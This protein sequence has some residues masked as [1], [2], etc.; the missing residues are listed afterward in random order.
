MRI[1][2][3]T[4]GGATTGQAP[5]SLQALDVGQP[6]LSLPVDRPR[7]V[8]QD[9]AAGQLAIR[10]DAAILARIGALAERAGTDAGT[11]LLSQWLV[12]LA[13]LSGQAEFSL[14]LATRAD[15]D[16]GGVLHVSLV[17]GTTVSDLVKGIHAARASA[18][19]GAF[20]TADGTPGVPS[21]VVF[22]GADPSTT[23]AGTHRFDLSLAGI[24]A[25]GATDLRLVYSEALFDRSSAE[26]FAGCYQTLLDAAANDPSCAFDRLP[27]ISPDERRQ[28]IHDWNQ[29]KVF[30][31]G[32]CLSQAF[33]SSAARW[34]DA[35]AVTYGDA[36][37]TYAELNIRANRMAHHL[38][39]LGVGPD[40]R[41]AL[42]VERGLDMVV[43][44]LAVLKAGGAY[45]PLDPVY[46]IDRLRFVLEDCGP[47]AI[48]AARSLYDQLQSELPWVDITDDFAAQPESN[49]VSPDLSPSSLA[50]VI[51]TSGSTGQPKGVMIEHQD[52]VRL[53]D[54]TQSWFNFSS[55]DVWT[56][57]HSY[58][59]D[60]SVWE[61]WGAFLHGGRLVVVPKETARSPRDFYQLVSDEKVTILNQTPSAFRS[62]IAAQG[63]S[64]Q[65]HDLRHV[66]FGGETL[67]LASLRPWY[68]NNVGHRCE[69]VNGYG[70][71]ETTVFVTFRPLAAAD[72]ARRG[73]SP[74]GTCIPDQRTYVLDPHGE[75]VPVG[76]VGELYVGGAGIARGYL[77]R[78]ELS[79]QRFLPDPFTGGRMYRSGDLA[80]WL[81]DG[82][83]EFL[84][85]NDFQVKIRGFRIELGEIEAR[86]A[87]HPDIGDVVVLARDDDFGEKRLVAYFVP[88]AGAAVG[89]GGINTDAL[90]RHVGSELPEHMVPS[91][92]VQLTE[93]PLTPNGKMDRTALPAP[94]HARPSLATAYEP[95]ANALEQLLCSAFSRVLGIDAIGRHDNFFS[96]GGNSM[97]AIR[98]L[99]AVR[100][101]RAQTSVIP[102]TTVFH[103][104]T[105]ATLALA[106]DEP[107]ATGIDAARL[108]N[109]LRR[110]GRKFDDEPIAI[111]AMAGRFPGAPMSRH[112]G[113]TCARAA[114]RSPVSR[115]RTSIPPSA[116]RRMPGLREGARRHRRRRAV[117]RRVLRHLA[118]RSR[119]DGSAAAHLPRAVL[120]V[121]G[122]RRPRA[123][124]LRGADRRLRRHVQRHL[125]PAPC[126]RASRPDRAARRV[127]GDAGQ[128]EGLH[129]HARRAQ[130]QPD[131]AGDQRAH[132]LLDLAGGD[133]AGGRQPARR[134]VRHGARRRRVDHLS[135]AQRLPATRKASMLSPDGHTRSFDARGAGHRVQRR[136]GGGAAQ[137]PV[138]CARRRRPDPRRDP[139]RR[140]STT[141]APR[142]PASPRRASTGR[143]R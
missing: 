50:Y 5:A 94:G 11:V 44:V 113:T 84:G 56:L 16:K 13:R 10:L 48:L 18:K 90:R 7:T 85:R 73:P 136:R 127:P 130:A 87:T 20:F 135:A 21:I 76:V 103:S 121:P 54:A 66:I 116:C 47:V 139:R 24:G 122:A 86:L 89:E 95:A 123:G 140:A 132:R 62:F 1:D 65:P 25:D 30:P 59:F 17:A 8:G 125:L 55:D 60:F 110:G 15:D 69:L 36:K 126:C 75:P 96:L 51:Y 61:I 134:P 49:P 117:R 41:V 52:V 124:R 82:S 29:G 112:S 137:A 53:F 40:K 105:P 80:R 109:A 111:I 58:A 72:V 14:G 26:R 77:N 104:P 9:A 115:P 2:S 57:F 79:A 37:L 108:G 22:D 102:A 27:M 118:A 43:G 91:A 45:V 129:R 106:L 46:P 131:R 119:A 74:I 63:N 6:L 28:V 32:H 78:P 68:D 142:R 98:L 71:T 23:E 141:T 42:C 83:L 99:E 92:W 64:D 38:K 35:V 33:E 128:R 67:E 4:T 100:T 88:S 143:R 93:F 70:I 3:K 34:S 138:R 114:S 81:P 107:S 12:L 39:A 97:L 31:V 133:R 120:G 19:T 101:A